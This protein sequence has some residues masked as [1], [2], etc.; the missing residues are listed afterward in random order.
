M[1]REKI[2]GIFLL[3]YILQT[4]LSATFIIKD[5][6]GIHPE[7]HNQVD[8]MGAELLKKTG[9]SPYIL[10]LKTTNG[11]SLSK[12]GAEE[13]AKLSPNSLILTFT[14]L[15]KK[16]DIV[17]NSEVLKLFDKEQ[18]LSPYPWSGTILPILGEKIKKDIRHK[19]SVALFNGY[20]DIVEQIAETKSVVL[21]SAVGS[22]N[23][24]VINIIRA[25]FYG[26]IV[27]ALGYIVYRKYFQ[28]KDTDV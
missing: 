22:S 26:I 27:F 16:V 6:L 21:D 28:K 13:L 19:Y 11:E 17:G 25:I 5:E 1:L 3:F 2:I 9:I 12:I 8:E 7:F 18:V 24:V 10:I 4:G 20:A 15:E 23:K 14:E